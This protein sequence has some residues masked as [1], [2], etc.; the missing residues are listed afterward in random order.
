MWDG[1]VND[2][3]INSKTQTNIYIGKENCQTDQ[4]LVTLCL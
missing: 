1:L 3:E 4:N 2:H